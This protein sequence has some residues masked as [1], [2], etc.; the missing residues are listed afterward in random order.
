MSYQS[1]SSSVG[2]HQHRLPR[3]TRR[4]WRRFSP[5]S[6]PGAP[7]S[8]RHSGRAGADASRRF[9]NSRPVWQR[10]QRGS[11]RG[12]HVDVGGS[13]MTG[14]DV[15]SAG[16]GAPKMSLKARIWT[17]HFSGADCGCRADFVVAADAGP[18]LDQ[19][20]TTSSGSDS[21]R[22]ADFGGQ[23]RNRKGGTSPRD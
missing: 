14:P 10:S 20:S 6:N 12:C 3:E 4:R 7:V 11:S 1:S 18:I 13:S 9:S 22:G 2:D 16:L 17:L 23:S 19:T 15:R 5:E 8:E 21:G